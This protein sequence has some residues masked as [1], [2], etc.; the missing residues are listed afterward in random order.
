MLIALR[1]DENLCQLMKPSD[2]E[3][4]WRGELISSLIVFPPE[5][6]TWYNAHKE[7]TAF[8][9]NKRGAVKNENY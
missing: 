4:D 9:L 5:Y 6:L 8:P 2:A 1:T 7:G 3:I